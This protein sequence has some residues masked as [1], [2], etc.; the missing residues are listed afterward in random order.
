M[1]IA[2]VRKSNLVRACAAMLAMTALLAPNA[3]AQP[4]PMPGPCAAVPG[5]W[6]WFSDATAYIHANGTLRSSNAVTADWTCRGGRIRIYWSTGAV[7]E[8]V[9]SYDGDRLSG[10]NQ[11]STPV[12]AQRMGDF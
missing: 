1:E 8:L 9:I 5:V 7:D 10:F 12:S 6:H 3:W 2:M 11:D 4:Y